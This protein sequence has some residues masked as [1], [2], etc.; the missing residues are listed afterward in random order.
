MASQTPGIQLLLA[1]EQRTAHRIAEAKK[2]RI[3]R[4]KQAKE[5]ALEEIE[6]YR[7]ERE[8]KL[9]ELEE[10]LDK[11]REQDAEKIEMKTKFRIDK[12]KNSV[13]KNKQVVIDKILELIC[14]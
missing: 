8:K 12:M 5:E 10:E 1:A 7:Q 6:M 4:L 3:K 9:E 14:E 13:D 2:K 11:L